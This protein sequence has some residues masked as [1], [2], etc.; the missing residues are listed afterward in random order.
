[1]FLWW[2]L[3]SSGCPTME[4]WHVSKKKN[5]VLVAGLVIPIEDKNNLNL[6]LFLIQNTSTQFYLWAQS[7]AA[8]VQNPI[9]TKIQA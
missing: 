2:L 8:H 1:M 6:G 4:L 3:A 9:H 7:S 5:G